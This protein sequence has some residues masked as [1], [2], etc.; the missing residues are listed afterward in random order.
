MYDLEEIPL[1]TP[2]A[3]G[4]ADLETWEMVVK[5]KNA[6]V[7]PGRAAGPGCSG[8]RG[9]GRREREAHAE[10][11]DVLHGAAAPLLH[12]AREK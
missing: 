2:A 12:V 10:A 9:V 6:L 11:L 4:K 8:D 1:K 3:G 7:G 5:L